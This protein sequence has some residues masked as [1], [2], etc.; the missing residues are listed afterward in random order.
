MRRKRSSTPHAGPSTVPTGNDDAVSRTASKIVKLDE[1]PT[2]LPP[3]DNDSI[4]SG[5]IPFESE[6]RVARRDRFSM[7]LVVR[8]QRIFGAR[9]N[10]EISEGEARIMLG[11]LTDFYE[12][13]V[14]RMCRLRREQHAAGSKPGK[15]G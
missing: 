7:G 11:D 10:R 14:V 6:P 15:R 12:L 2:S 3:G 1:P 9:L 5:T 13:A 4:P 8:A